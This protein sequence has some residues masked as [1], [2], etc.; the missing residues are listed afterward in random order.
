MYFFL[1]TDFTNC[2]Q[3]LSF[4]PDSI[5]RTTRFYVFFPADEKIRKIEFRLYIK[6][7]KTELTIAIYHFSSIDQDFNAVC[8]D[9]L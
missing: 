7:T 6:K 8:K 5:L 3:Y 9:T 1:R 2:L 4:L